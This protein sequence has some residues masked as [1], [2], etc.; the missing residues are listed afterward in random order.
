MK[1][2]KGNIMSDIKYQFSDVAKA[3]DYSQ[4]LIDSL[5]DQVNSLQ[6]EIRFLRE[7]LKVKN[8]LLEIT[9][10]SKKIDSSTIYPSRQQIDSQT[11]KISDEKKCC[12][13]NINGNN[14]ITIKP[15]TQKGSVEISVESKN[16]SDIKNNAH[17]E[18]GIA[19]NATEDICDTQNNSDVNHIKND[20]KKPDNQL[21]HNLLKDTRQKNDSQFNTCTKNGSISGDTQQQQEKVLRPPKKSA[22]IVGD[23]MIKKIDGYLLTSSINHKYIVKVRPFVTAKTDDMYDHIKPTQR[24]FQPNVYISHVGTNDL[25]TDITPEEI[26]E[27][28]I[29]FSKHLKSE[30]NEVVVSG[31]VPRGDYYKEK[32]EAV[33]KVL[34]DACTKENMHFICHSSI[35]VKRHLNRSNLHLNDNGILPLVRNFKNF[36]NNF[37]SV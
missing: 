14:N 25:P 36:L 23:S 2:L 15:L 19:T 33:S 28:I 8:N 27:K 29:T 6:N 30:D 17:E 10:T 5:K 32:A 1:H 3:K 31:I 7:E 18:R 26:S 4:L 9:I 21:Y 34:K 35:N 20:A 22:F 12:L 16:N 24:N 11:Q 37:E 13:I